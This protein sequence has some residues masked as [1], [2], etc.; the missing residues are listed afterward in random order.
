MGGKLSS[1]F[2]SDFKTDTF[3]LNSEESESIHLQTQKSTFVSH[4]PSSQLPIF[5][6][7]SSPW[8]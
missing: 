1:P 7:L 6:E 4:L 5:V 8:C 2:R 3:D